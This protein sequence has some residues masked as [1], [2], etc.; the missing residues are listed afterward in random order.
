MMIILDLYLMEVSSHF[1]ISLNVH[2]Y[3]F[4]YSFIL[5]NPEI[6]INYIT[7]NVSCY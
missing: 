7:K 6:L 1:F 2:G 4:T 5:L 3:Y